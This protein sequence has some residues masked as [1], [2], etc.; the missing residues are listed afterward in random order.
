MSRVSESGSR[1]RVIHDLLYP[2]PTPRFWG[3]VAAR[4]DSTEVAQAFLL[5][6]AGLQKQNK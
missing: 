1:N 3:A 6:R 2:R 4:M 5:L